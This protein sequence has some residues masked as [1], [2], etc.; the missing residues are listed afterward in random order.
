MKRLAFLMGCLCLLC[1]VLQG[2]KIGFNQR[3]WETAD[4]LWQRADKVADSPQKIKLLFEMADSLT[5]Q[6]GQ[7]MRFVMKALALSLTFHQKDL[8]AEAHLR[9]AELMYQTELEFWDRSPSFFKRY[10][11]KGVRENR[12]KALMIAKEIGR[13][14]LQIKTLNALGVVLDK[15]NKPRYALDTFKLA[16]S[17]AWSSKD[18]VQV[19]EVNKNCALLYLGL[20]R[21]DSA[22]TFYIE[23]QRLATAKN[24]FILKADVLEGWG[25]FYLTKQHIDDF[26]QENLSFIHVRLGTP[27]YFRRF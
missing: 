23:N 24:D 22:R 21:S 8:E 1:N 26:E 5:E 6:S 18:T 20:G 12:I 7:S 2:Q 17:L 16:K 13:K 4:L 3:T 15:E 27:Q 10:D 11:F 19:I 25:N 9:I 14:D